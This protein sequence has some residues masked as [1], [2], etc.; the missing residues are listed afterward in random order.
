MKILIGLI[1][2]VVGIAWYFVPSAAL[3]GFIAGL[4]Y[5]LRLQALVTLIVACIGFFLFFIGLI[6][7]WMGYDDY[8]M[9]AEMK[10][11]ESKEEKKEEKK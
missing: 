4:A 9:E 3:D 5:T 6:V 11:E 8:K 2:I 1:L 10:K 7:A